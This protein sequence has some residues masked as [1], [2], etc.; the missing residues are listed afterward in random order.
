MRK[1]PGHYYDACA[2]AHTVGHDVTRHIINRVWMLIIIF[3]TFSSLVQ[4]TSMLLDA[5][6]RR[7]EVLKREI[8]NNNITQSNGHEGGL[9]PHVREKASFCQIYGM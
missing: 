9:R 7:L 8:N 1:L 4:V 2:T 5:E 3:T 6:R